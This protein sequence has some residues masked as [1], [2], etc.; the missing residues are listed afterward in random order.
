MLNQ[1]A[2]V[3]C[4]G[5]TMVAAVYTKPIS[6]GA[7]LPDTL[8][9]TNEGSYIAQVEHIHQ[10]LVKVVGSDV[11]VVCEGYPSTTAIIKFDGFDTS[12]RYKDVKELSKSNQVKHKPERPND[13]RVDGDVNWEHTFNAP[14]GSITSLSNSKFLLELPDGREWT[15]YGTACTV[16]NNSPGCLVTGEYIDIRV[17][18]NS[19]RGGQLVIN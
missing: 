10:G 8:T 16:T 14:R 18:R 6:A 13:V 15:V 3:L 5:L 7:Q 11:T 12:C 9:N 19:W 17:V 1:I 4:L 2:S